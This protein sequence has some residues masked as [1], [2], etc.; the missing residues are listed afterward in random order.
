MIAFL[1]IVITTQNFAWSNFFSSFLNNL[2][3]LKRGRKKS[4]WAIAV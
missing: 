3:F 1:Q 4:I 2:L